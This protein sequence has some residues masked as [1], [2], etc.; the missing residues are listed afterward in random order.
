MNPVPR[1]AARAFNRPLGIE[2]G[3]ASAFLHAFG[4]RLGG[5]DDVQAG[6]LGDPLREERDDYG[7]SV[8]EL[9]R[10]GPVA[11]IEIE[12][13]L[14]HKGRFTGQYCGNTSYEGLLTQLL[15]AAEDPSVAGVVLECD[16]PGGEISGL[17]DCAG[18]LAA[19]SDAKPTLAILTDMACSA[20]YVLASA[21]RGI[22][23]PAH[24]RAG[25]IGALTIH[26]DESAA[27]ARAGLVVTPLFAGRHKVDGHPFAAL[28]DEVRARIEADLEATRQDM[29]R[30]IG[31]RRPEL[32]RDG[33]LATEAQHYA[34]AEALSLKLVDA[35]AHPTEAFAAFC[36]ACA[37][38]PG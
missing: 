19:L 9:R 11:V 32:G 22:V 34:G 25:S 28:P 37:T 4:A 17:M 12:G 35:V 7:R 6:R 27:L 5:V 3:A 14:V 33:A 38:P 8:A 29:A 36:A 10:V 20:A 21:C 2:P 15:M 18:R 26:V 1:L 13:V 30:F 16:S 24:G 31:E 23:M